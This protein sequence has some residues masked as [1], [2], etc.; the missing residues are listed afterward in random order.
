M[1]DSHLA[2]EEQH[3]RCPF[4]IGRLNPDRGYVHVFDDTSLDV[5]MNYLDTVSDFIAYLSKKEILLAGELH[6]RAAGE[7]ELLGEYVRRL[8]IEED[9][10]FL[11]PK[12]TT[13]VLF[14]KGL[15]EKFLQSNERRAQE[16]ANEISYSWDFLVEK[17]LRH[18]MTGTQYTC[19]D[20]R[21]GEQE[22]IFRWLAREN[23]TRRRMLAKAFVGLLRKTPADYRASRLMKPSRSGDPYF[24]FLLLP[25][26]RSLKETEYRQARNQLL[27]EYL[28]VVKLDF[29]DAEHIVGIA[30]ETLGRDDYRSE[31]LLYLDAT[32]WNSQLEESARKSKIELGIF[33]DVKTFAGREQEYPTDDR[34]KV[35]TIVSRNSPC[36]CG[37]GKRYKRCCGADIHR[38]KKGK[39]FGKAGKIGGN[40]EGK[41]GDGKFGDRRD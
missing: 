21:I 2:G 18:L 1:L 41:F 14:P 13:H 9:H 16:R 7:E 17:F 27:Q 36:I 35:R 25:Y 3:L 10:D 23:R 37:S 39:L 8:N 22:K 40:S 33:T 28:M 32:H 20:A 24:L 29:P 5:V 26:Y 11:I 34:K 31:D 12:G 38:K 6:I 19:S 30:T 4:T 15:W